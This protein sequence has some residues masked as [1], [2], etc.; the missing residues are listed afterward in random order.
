MH[1]PSISI[2]MNCYNSDRFLEEAID[3]VYAQTIDDWEI[4]FWDNASTDQSGV[5][6]RSY[7]DRLKYFRSEDTTLL[8]EARNFALKEVS[9]KYVAFLDCDDLYFPDKLRKQIAL[10]DSNDYAMCYGSAIIINESGRQIRRNTTKNRS[11]FVFGQLLSHYEINMQSVMVR[12]SV[13]TDNNFEFDSNLKYSPDYNLFMRIASTYNIGV[14]NDVLVQ[15]RVWDGSLSSKS[16]DIAPYEIRITLDQIVE[17]FPELRERFALEFDKAY[18]KLHYYKA[19]SS[20]Y[21]NDR[22][23]ARMELRTIIYSK[24]EYLLLYLL[25]FFPIPSH[26]ILKI[27]RR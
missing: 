23:I 6:A 16:I 11:G 13:L 12:R 17:Q 15:Y 25:L 9:G 14:I 4:I 3:S 18:D 27:L 8:G 26:I 21:R 5:I 7:D 24:I 20:I 1:R 22:K 2:I 10:M 19:L